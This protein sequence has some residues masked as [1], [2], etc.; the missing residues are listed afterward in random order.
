MQ[1]QLYNNILIHI[2]YQKTGS[3]W[4]Q[5][6]LF[7]RE[8]SVFEPL[9]EKEK[10]ASNLASHFF[11]GLDDNVLSPFDLNED[12]IRKQLGDYLNANPIPDHKVPVLSNERLA[13][14][15][16]AGGFDAVNIA[17]RL[18]NVFPGGKI[19][20]TVRE[21]K[22]FMLSI[23]FEYLNKGGTMSLK[24]Y[25]STRY[26]GKRPFFSPHHMDYLHLVKY[27][28]QL[29]GAENV[30]VLPFE[31]FQRKPEDFIARIGKLV[32]KEVL[33]NHLKVED[34]INQTQKHFA[35]YYLKSLNRLRFSN[36]LNNFSQL[37]RRPT[38][39]AAKAFVTLFSFFI[40]KSWNQT[41][42]SK[43]RREI[44]YW[45]GDRYANSNRELSR[46]IGVDLS[47]FDY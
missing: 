25:L 8:N 3:T 43:M 42:K 39:K 21:Q 16:H 14:N 17:N 45:A 20:I 31:L 24:K 27:Y 34:K 1:D 18:K 10:G 15:A 28:M 12:G 7:V 5:H 46:L 2:G 40:P 41:L 4:L 36:S 44:E 37:K 26:D 19:L 32:G 9:S 33:I 30:C 22:S 13:G 38:A 6:C 11:R 35:K 47:E 29:F 23:Y